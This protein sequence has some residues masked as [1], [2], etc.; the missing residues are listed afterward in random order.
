MPYVDIINQSSMGFYF[1]WNAAYVQY[2]V[3]IATHVL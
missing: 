3:Q 2:A 1:G